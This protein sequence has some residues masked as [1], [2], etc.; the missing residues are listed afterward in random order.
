MAFGDFIIEN[1]S[2][3]HWPILAGHT[4]NLPSCRNLI[5][6]CLYSS[7]GKKSEIL[8]DKKT[9]NGVVNPIIEFTFLII[10]LSLVVSAHSWIFE[11]LK[12]NLPNQLITI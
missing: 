12:A 5:M 4:F 7:G 6:N 2:L 8:A 9:H 3:N 10:Y 1:Q 11:I